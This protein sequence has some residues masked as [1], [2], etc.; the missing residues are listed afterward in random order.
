MWYQFF[1]YGLFTPYVRGAVRPWIVGMEN[2]PK[3]GGAILAG[4]HLAAGDTFMFPASIRRQVTFAAKAE[5]FQ[6]DRGV[7]SKIVAWFL[8]AVGQVPMDR[9]GG[10]ASAKAV[11][12]IVEAVRGGSLAMIFPE[13][14]RS[15]DGRLYR[16][17]TGVARMALAAGAP[18]IPVGI[19]GTRA[20]KGLFG[21][22]VVRRPGFIIGEPMD[23]SAWEGAHDQ[24]TLRWITDEVMAAIQEL[25][26]QDYVDVYASRV[27]YGD[28]KDHDISD[29]EKE[30]PGGGDPPPPPERAP[31]A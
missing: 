30:R 9:G 2:I 25:T 21:I 5:L 28:L 11:G 15:P 14:T 18:V 31:E 16:G 12:P 17:R 6:G 29:R 22:P 19:I 13:G 7:T 26:G 20:H 23:F 4:N 8:R 3:H 27:K 10:M 1:K 24:R